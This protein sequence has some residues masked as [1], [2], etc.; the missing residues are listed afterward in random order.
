MV[1]NQPGFVKTGEYPFLKPLTRSQMAKDLG[2]HESTISRA[3]A[4]KFIQLASRD[5]VPFD[6]FFKPALKIQKMIEDI[7]AM[8][9]PDAPLSDERIA[10]LLAKKGVVVARRTVNKYRDRS[11]LLSSRMRKSA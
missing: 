2:V 10:S 1:E 11:K 6:V 4:G 7:L 3:T 5:V 9:N 8:E